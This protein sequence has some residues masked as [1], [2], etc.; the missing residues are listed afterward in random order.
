MNANAAGIARVGAD[1]DAFAE[2]GQHLPARAAGAE[3][4]LR[5][6]NGDALEIPGD[7]R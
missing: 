3:R 5:S 7:L 4:G 1:D 6:D 2:F